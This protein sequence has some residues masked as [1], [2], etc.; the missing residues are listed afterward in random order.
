MVMVGGLLKRS[1]MGKVEFF[2]LILFQLGLTAKMFTLSL[3][4]VERYV[5]VQTKVISYIFLV[6]LVLSF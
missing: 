3:Y 5:I 4:V 2:V 1:S 6:F